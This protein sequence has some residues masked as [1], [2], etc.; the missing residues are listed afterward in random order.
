MTRF[1]PFQI[2]ESDT[3]YSEFPNACFAECF[4]FTVVT[5]STLCNYNTLWSNLTVLNLT[6]LMYV[7]D[8]FG[9]IFP[10]PNACLAACWDFTNN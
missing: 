3:I 4:G 5:D 9:I 10:V 7:Q 1:V 6:A 8:S 2:S